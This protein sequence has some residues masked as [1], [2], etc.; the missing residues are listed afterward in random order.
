MTPEQAGWRTALWPGAK[1]Q[2]GR[3]EDE[4]PENRQEGGAEQP[5]LGVLP[6]LPP[7]AWR[8]LL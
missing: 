7:W 8:P 5:L 3:S 1:A 6:L 2:A 4:C